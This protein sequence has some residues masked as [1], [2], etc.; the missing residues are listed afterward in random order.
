MLAVVILLALLLIVSVLGF[1]AFVVA[2]SPTPKWLLDRHDYLGAE[3]PKQLEWLTIG[4]FPIHAQCGEMTVD[5]D[6]NLRGT[7][8]WVTPPNPVKGLT[9]HRRREGRER[10]GTYRTDDPAFDGAFVTFAS[11]AD[12]LPCRSR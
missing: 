12:A 3:L 7:T 2:L 4:K 1:V 5:I 11:E 10:D 6:S 8:I 9:V